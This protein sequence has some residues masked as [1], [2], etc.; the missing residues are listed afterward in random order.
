MIIDVLKTQYLVQRANVKVVV[1]PYQSAGH[2]QSSG[3]GLDL[4][5]FASSRL[6]V[7][8]RIDVA[9]STAADVQHAIFRQC[10][11]PCIGYLAGHHLNAKTR[12]KRQPGD[13]GF[14][15]QGGRGG[16]A[17]DAGQQSS[18][19]RNIRFLYFE[20]GLSSTAT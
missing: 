4:D 1:V 11:L 20:H 15:R 9:G 10:H 14:H 13:V 18:Q 2:L 3:N 19:D 7:S 16:D 6:P 12:W 17:S 8:D 5:C